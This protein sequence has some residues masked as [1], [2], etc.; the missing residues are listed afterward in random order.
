MVQQERK[1]E[2]IRLRLHYHTG[3]HSQVAFI[4][5]TRRYRRYV[6][7][8]VDKEDAPTF[9]KLAF[10]VHSMRRSDGN[11]VCRLFK[12]A[13]E[14]AAHVLRCIFQGL[15]ETSNG[16]RPHERVDDIYRH[17]GLGIPVWQRPMNARNENKDVAKAQQHSIE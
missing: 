6:F 16:L 3:K 7:R 15:I 12:H 9:D 1:R 14:C 2:K 8:S 5:I 10:F 17:P 4:G 13:R 11:R